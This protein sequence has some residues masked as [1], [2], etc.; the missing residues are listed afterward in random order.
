MIYLSVSIVLGCALLNK[1]ACKWIAESRNEIARVRA[2]IARI[3][4]ENC[5]VKY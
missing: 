5:P 1:I 2:E 3:E 4:F